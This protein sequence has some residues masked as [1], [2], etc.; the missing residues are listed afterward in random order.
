MTRF[1]RTWM[2]GWCWGVALFGLVLAGAGLEATSGP[3]RLIFGLL[4]GPEALELNAQMRF[5]VALMGAV[6]L[7]W[8]LT[9]LAAIGAAHQLGERART[10]WRGITAS[11]LVW[12]VLDSS[13][14][15]A[16][17]FGLNAV[18]NTVI[19]A[20]FLVPILRGGVLR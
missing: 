13:L 6:T 14:S 8:A 11:L 5:S 9:L 18:S 20:A 10:T 7:G 1:W 17:G 16:T 4:D 12:Y 19:F 3:T 2:T 15:V